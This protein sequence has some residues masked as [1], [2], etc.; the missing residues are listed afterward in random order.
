MNIAIVTPAP[1]GSRKGTRVTY[2]AGNHDDP[3]LVSRVI[4]GDRDALE[5]VFRRYGGA[6][7]SLA[8]RVLRNETLAEDVAQEAF[9]SEAT[10]RTHV[11]GARVMRSESSAVGACSEIEGDAGAGTGAVLEQWR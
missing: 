3:E 4:D 2:V 8:F 5:T 11:P 1:P 7:Q 10:V 9:V 6:V